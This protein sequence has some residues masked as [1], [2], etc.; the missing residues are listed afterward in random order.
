MLVIITI[1]ATGLAQVGDDLNGSYCLKSSNYVHV[2]SR[3]WAGLG[4]ANVGRGLLQI[5]RLPKRAKSDKMLAFPKSFSLWS[6]GS[7][8]I[9]LSISFF[10]CNFRFLLLESRMLTLCYALFWLTAL[11]SLAKFSSMVLLQRWFCL[12]SAQ[13]GSKL[14]SEHQL[15]N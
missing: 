15:L 9:L 7:A 1:I 13:V 2:C 5:L 12:S 10:F 11:W 8:K 14:D 3:I 4:A 6:T